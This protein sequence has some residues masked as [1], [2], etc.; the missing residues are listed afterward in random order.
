MLL[1]IIVSEEVWSSGHSLL[2]LDISLKPNK[3]TMDIKLWKEWMDEI[4][5]ELKL[6]RTNIVK[7]EKELANFRNNNPRRERCDR[8]WS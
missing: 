5:K 3:L 4:H 6:V 2:S 7:R 8:S 1:I